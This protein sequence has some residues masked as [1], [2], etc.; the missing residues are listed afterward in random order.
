MAKWVK[1]A[2]IKLTLPGSASPGVKN[3]PANKYDVWA[4]RLKEQ[5]QAN[6]VLKR[7]FWILASLAVC[8]GSA[9]A[10]LLLVKG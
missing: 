8:E 1:E 10:Y 3:V 4:K 7:C 2:R 6:T 9:I 5:Q